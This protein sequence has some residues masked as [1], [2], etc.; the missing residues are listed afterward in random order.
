MG[1]WEIL[2]DGRSLRDEAPTENLG[3]ALRVEWTMFDGAPTGSDEAPGLVQTLYPFAAG[4]ALVHTEPGQRSSA[5]ESTAGG[6]YRA[7][8]RLDDHL[9][10]LGI[11]AEVVVDAPAAAAEASAPAGDERPAGWPRLAWVVGA[12]VLGAGVVAVALRRA[13][14]GAPAPAA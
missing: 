9:A 12:A 3:P 1:V 8:D 14:R 13:D 11:S 6:W 4:G 10:A 2:G 5:F 7:P